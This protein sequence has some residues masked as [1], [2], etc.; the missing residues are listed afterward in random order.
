MMSFLLVFTTMMLG[1]VSATSAS[2]D[3]TNGDG[4]IEPPAV[5]PNPKG[6]RQWLKDNRQLKKQWDTENGC[7]IPVSNCCAGSWDLLWRCLDC[8][9]STIAT[10]VSCCIPGNSLRGNPRGKP[11]KRGADQKA[12]VARPSSP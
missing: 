1:F 10:P 6:D 5:W 12:R 3:D 4:E 7:C 11:A 2:I 9:L 8:C